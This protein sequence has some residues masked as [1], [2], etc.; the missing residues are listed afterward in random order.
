[1]SKQLKDKINEIDYAWLQIS[2]LHIFE[3]TDWN[4][5][6]SKI[7]DLKN[8]KH[9]KFIVVTGD[10]HQYGESYDKTKL[11]LNQLL[12][13]CN[14]DKKNIYIVPGN[15]DS[16]DIKFKQA[17]VDAIE[18]HVEEN[19]DIYTAYFQKGAL[20]DCFDQFNVFIK[21]FYGDYLPKEYLHAE[22]VSIINWNDKINILH[23]NTAINC[24]RNND[25]QQIIDIK[26]LSSIKNEI[27]NNNPIIIIAHH[28]F[29]KL[30]ESHQNVLR[31]IITDLNVRAYLCGDLHKRKVEMIK[32]NKNSNS[33]IPCIVCAKSAIDNRDDYSDIGL[34]LYL[35]EANS[36]K[37]YVNP[38]IWDNNNKNFVY[39]NKFSY[40]DEDLIVDLQ[41]NNIL[42]KESV[43]REKITTLEKGSNTSLKKS[44]WLPDAEEADGEQTRFNTYS[45]IDKVNLFLE[46]F[47]KL[48]IVAV[49]GIGK[50]FVLQIKKIKVQKNETVLTLPILNEKPSK[51][52]NW[53]TD[54]IAIP[55]Y[56]NINTLKDLNILR[57]LWKYS[58]LVY[59]INQIINIENRIET[60]NYWWSDKSPSNRLLNKLSE[61]MN[62]KLI[63]K[64]TYEFCTL[65]IYTNFSFTFKSILQSDNWTYNIGKDYDKL[66]S[67]KKDIIDTLFKLNKK[68]VAI[69]LDKIDQVIEPL[70][71]EPPLDCDICKKREKV[72]KCE[73][74][75]KNTEFCLTSPMC[76]T[77][78]CY[79]CAN[80]LSPYS[81]IGLRLYGNDEGKKHINLWQYFQLALIN[82]IQDLNNDFQWKIKVYFTLR[83]EA[84]FCEKY[85]FGEHV[86]KKINILDTLWYSRKEQLQIFYECILHQ[87]KQLL[88][89]NNIEIN[90]NNFEYAF[91]GINK[92]CHPYSR[93]LY[94]SVF[95]SIY[96]HS[97]DR[98]R[99]IQYYAQEL[100][101]MIYELKMI[102]SEDERGEKIKDKIE[103]I[104][105]EL[106]YRKTNADKS[107]NTCYYFEKNKLLPNY[108]ANVSNFEN[109]LKMF[110]KNVL[111]LDEIKYICKRI[112]NKRGKCAKNCSS[113]KAELRPFSMLYQIGY[114][115]TIKFENS[116]NKYVKQK[117]IDS[118]DVTYVTGIDIIG[119]TMDNNTIYLLHP[120]LTKSIDRFFNKIKH[121]NYF[122]IGKD[123]KVEKNIVEKILNDYNKMSIDEFEN[124][125]FNIPS[126]E[127]YI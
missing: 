72:N 67:L 80:Y 116:R 20:V 94:E 26:K 111:F 38:Y 81:D 43:I 7:Q 47:T 102:D 75:R 13:I 57:K 17:F 34:I 11:F 119:E 74:T 113:C 64:D 93:Q 6:K 56:F 51:E 121:F 120:A 41:T 69:F 66:V 30:H 29:E 32:T 5:L 87:N 10:L 52:N 79:G 123:S 83:N 37:V 27:K 110:E 8:I 22:Q 115:G 39:D 117:F 108:W 1:M 24:Y 58:L 63:S 97:F 40:D 60:N 101:K 62:N 3:G 48:G 35:K 70:S 124:E 36:Q 54:T 95:N 50:T 15:H 122:I 104:A 31:R 109:L 19:Q 61:S 71:A 65:D 25:L 106:A 127:K 103:Q 78:C 88:F 4:I 21:D 82:A 105:A 99:D 2:D 90:K 89:D 77:Q 118:K 12:E 14:I 49:K 107:I 85:V 28:P 23:L 86:R 46:D 91:I 100:T 96:R 59:S 53:G 9:V 18:N 114:L 84:F 44:I 68:Y 45:H 112:N 76:S 42:D 92:L 126:D 33:A 55:D 16:M 125:Y 73:N 98:T